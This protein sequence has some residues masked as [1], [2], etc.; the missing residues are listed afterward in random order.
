MFGEVY[1]AKWNDRSVAVKVLHEHHFLR[2]RD[3]QVERFQAECKILARLQHKNV[4]ELLE[5]V[6][7]HSSPP[8]L[9]T[10]LLDCDLAKYI[11][12]LHPKKVPFPDAV[13]I[14]SDVAEGLA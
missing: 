13:S 8:V 5:F 10:E 6:I 4:V 1:R 12:S 7:C 9:I 2:D 11:T 3:R 14:M